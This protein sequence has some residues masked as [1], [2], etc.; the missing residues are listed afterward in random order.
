MRIQFESNDLVIFES[1]LFRTTT[2][3]I[4]GNDHIILVD[5]NWFP[6]ELQF[7]K[8]YIFNLAFKK[9]KYLFFTHSDYDHI[10]GYNFFTEYKTVA[11]RN[12]VNQKAKEAIL[13]K[14]RTIDDDNYTLREYT[15]TFPAID[16]VI[17]DEQTHIQLGTETYKV[18]YILGHND[19]S[20]YLMDEDKG[21]LV[22]GDYLS[23]IE[24]PYLYHSFQAYMD[25]LTTLSDIISTG[26]ASM[27]IPGHGDFTTDQPEMKRRINDSLDYLKQISDQHLGKEKFKFE[28][29]VKRYS[30][31]KVMTKFHEANLALLRKE[32]DM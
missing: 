11:S 9:E 13:D 17:E 27:L 14:I 2:T 25:S 3:L 16:M 32:F 6:N 12:F 8:D 23:N 30:F 24:F 7:I 31:P 20:I 21:I 5:P 10:I 26:K 28:S 18:G 1:A 19:D 15:V 22:V 29:Y 4:I